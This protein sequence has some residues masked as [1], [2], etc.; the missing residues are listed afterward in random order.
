MD[1]FE[2]WWNR[3][4]GPRNFVEEIARHIDTKTFCALVLSV[5][6]NGLPWHER[7]LDILIKRQAHANDMELVVRDGAEVK[8]GI[9]EFL[10]EEC[11]DDSQRANYNRCSYRTTVDEFLVR[12]GVFNGKIIWL[13]NVGDV[14]K[15]KKHLFSNYEKK[16]SGKPVI[17]VLETT[18]EDAAGDEKTGVLKYFDCVSEYDVH[19][20]ASLVAAESANEPG[21]R[22]YIT[23]VAEILCGYDVESA[24]S[25]ISDND[26]KDMNIVE[27]F[28]DN[29]NTA[30]MDRDWIGRKLWLAQLQAA[31][32]RIEE[33]RV[34]FVDKH[35]D[36]LLTSVPNL[37]NVEEPY[38]V[39]LRHMVFLF[40][41]RELI[42]DR[43]EYA[44]VRLLH[45]L[46]N[47][48]AHMEYC[49][50]GEMYGLLSGGAVFF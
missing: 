13:Q 33:E 38:D 44:R 3:I 36:Q 11:A 24:V 27:I 47:K 42:V 16:M 2:T 26:F 31:F 18:G 4:T 10:L 40:R 43:Q 39:E 46:R 9:G 8:G 21:L 12:E 28:F 15:W 41:T 1:D 32:P 48:L 5:P 25:F 14:G 49:D 30:G 35:F 6:E 34:K 19:L 23:F 7:L 37:E 22:R 45:G 17:F 50:A 20:F 29:Y